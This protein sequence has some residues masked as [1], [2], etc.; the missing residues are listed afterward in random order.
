M[1]N[2]PY[3][4]IK[5]QCEPSLEPSQRDGSDEGLQCM[6]S[7]RN[8]KRYRRIIHFTPFYLELRHIRMINDDTV[9]CAYSFPVLFHF[10]YRKLKQVKSNENINDNNNN[11][12]K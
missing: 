7:L 11:R 5:I 8:K 2:Y 1:N 12:N 4:C 6:F 10:R 3:L 9:S